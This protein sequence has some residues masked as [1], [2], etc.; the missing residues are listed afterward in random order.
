MCISRRPGAAR[1]GRGGEAGFTMLEMVVAMVILMVG[2]LSLAQVLG[3]ALSVSNRGRG[4]TNTKLL[5]VSTLEQMENLRN[6]G[7]LT[8]GQI[9]NTGSV[10][11]TG[12]SFNFGGFQ[13]GLQA[14]SIDPGA[15]GIY[16]T[17]DDP[18]GTGQVRPGFQRQIVITSLGTNL[19]KVEVTLQYTDPGGAARTLKGTSYLNN[20]TRSNILR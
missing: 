7:E 6:T 14:V 19:K 2:L 20:D 18:T 17:A 1:P 16:G 15:D 13:T 9:A 10:D 8:F 3:Y 11:N 12:A 5:V 4:I